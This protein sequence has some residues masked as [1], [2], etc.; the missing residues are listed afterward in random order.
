MR[1]LLLLIVMG[2]A[3]PALLIS[4]SKAK[5]F[6]WADRIH[7]ARLWSGIVL[8]FAKTLVKVRNEN[9]IPLEN[10]YT[11]AANHMGKYDTTVLMAANPLDARFF[12]S[13]TEPWPYLKGFW[14]LTESVRFTP[15][16]LEDEAIHVS[17]LLSKQNNVTIYTR[18]LNGKVMDVR[19]LNGAYLSKTAIIPVAMLNT[20]GIARR[21]QRVLVSFCTPLHY[22]EYGEW[23]PETTLREIETRIQTELTALLGTN[24]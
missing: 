1:R 8:R 16:T 12:V 3:F 14:V 5:K 10:G 23:T 19:Q 24:N 15:Q 2:L 7:L 20:A 17:Q 9:L 11:F 21:R 22:E 6:E 4:R 13:K 18:D